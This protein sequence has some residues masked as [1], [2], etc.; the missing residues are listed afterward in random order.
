MPGKAGGDLGG[1]GRLPYLLTYLID[2]WKE[3]TKGHLPEMLATL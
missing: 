1:S 2:V 3:H